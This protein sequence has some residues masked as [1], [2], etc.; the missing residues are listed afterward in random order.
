MKTVLFQLWTF[1]YIYVENFNSFGVVWGDRL[2][3][4]KFVIY[5]DYLIWISID[6]RK[7]L[8]KQN[9]KK[10]QVSSRWYHAETITNTEYAEDLAILITT[11]AQAKSILHSLEQ[12]AGRIDLY[13][14]VNKTDFMWFN[15]KEGL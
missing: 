4:Y 3:P 5:L 13:V 6:K 8:K 1:S 7:K 2:A 15:E 12:A 9:T 11:S 10:K 14:N